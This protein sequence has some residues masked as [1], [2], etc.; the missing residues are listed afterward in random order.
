[1]KRV[2]APVSRVARLPRVNMSTAAP[3]KPPTAAKQAYRYSVEIAQMCYVFGETSDP[4]EDVVKFIEDTVR[5]QITD[6]ILQARLLS[7]RRLSRHLS[8]EDLVF[9]IRHDLSLVARLRSFLSWKDAADEL[10]RNMTKEQYQHYSDCRQSSFTYRKAKRFREFINLSLHLEG[11]TPTDDIIDVLGSFST[12]TINFI[13]HHWTLSFFP[14]PEI[15][16]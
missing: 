5:L 14:S 13:T 6:L 12:T 7:S 16:Q 9:L 8:V 3:E 2:G 1:M 4:S 11:T 15:S 10:T